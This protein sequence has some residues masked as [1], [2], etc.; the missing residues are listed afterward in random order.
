MKEKKEVIN[1]KLFLIFLLLI[2]IPFVSASFFNIPNIREVDLKN[3]NI[4]NL[5]TGMGTTATTTLNVT[6]GNTAPV[7]QN[8]SF[9]PASVSISEGTVTYLNVS[10]SAVDADGVSNFNNATAQVKIN[11]SSG[12]DGRSNST[13]KATRLNANVMNYTCN[14]P[15]WYWDSNGNW[16]INASVKDTPGAITQNV[17]ISFT[18]GSTTSMNMTPTSLAWSSIGPSSTNQL[19]SSNPITVTNIANNNITAANV[20]LTGINLE[21]ETTKTEYLLSSSFS[22]S[23]INSCDTGNIT[24]NSTTVGILS[25]NITAGNSSA[26]AATAK[27]Q[28]YACLENVTEGISQQSYSTGGA[29]GPWTVSIV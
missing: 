27:E 13:C 16:I 12:D 6:V 5:I 28:L 18:L 4:K 23:T 7:I 29:G 21:G 11:I 24:L 26:A 2:I 8:V 14:V 22:I 15:I 3:F 25:S 17:S 9:L 19:S 20:N 10:F 1:L